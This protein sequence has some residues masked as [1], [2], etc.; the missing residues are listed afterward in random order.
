MISETLFNR[1]QKVIPGGVNSPVRAF[2]AVGRSPIFIEKAQGCRIWSVDG[3]EYIDYCGSWGPIILGHSN[4]V[5]MEAVQSALQNGLSFGACTK[6]EVELAELICTAIPSVEKIRLVT[7]GTEAVMT[8][9]RLAR[10][11]TGRNKILKF[12]GC[13]HGHSDSMLVAAGSGLL[14]GGISSSKGVPDSV[15]G[16]TFIC[17]Y[18]DINSVSDIIESNGESIAAII[19]EPIAGNMGLVVPENGF[20]DG[21]R[22]AADKCKCVLIFDEVITGFR[23]GP[24]SYGNI[25]GVKPDLT[26]LG[27]IIGGGL[28][29]GAVGGR[30]EIIDLLA[31]AGPVYQAGTLSG[32][33]IAVCAGLAT[34]K[35]LISTNPYPKMEQLCSLLAN[36]VN[37]YA[38][39]KSFPAIVA[40]KGSLFTLYF[41]S[42]PAPRSLVEV[43]QSGTAQFATFYGK[44][45][46]KGIYL[47]PSQF[48]TA[49]FGASHTDKEVDQTTEAICSAL[50]QIFT[51]NN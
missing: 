20:L 26:T 24:T 1:A 27:K 48:E 2:K 28:P 14:T 40:N 16:D 12:D 34:L 5:V 7:S 50:D 32:N 19:V 23:F 8:A 38:E 13:Y 46:G 45:L 47:P 36:R 42:S 49:F 30:K 10:A 41:R 39:S 37:S 9:I 22:K 18:N 6:G 17:P 44:M 29:V 25:I 43:K 21:L 31:P 33:P 11:Y 3:D 51:S 4:P 35:H 15:A